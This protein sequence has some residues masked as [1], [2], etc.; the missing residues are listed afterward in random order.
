MKLI[1][2]FGGT[3][4]GSAERIENVGQIIKENSKENQLIINEGFPLR[5]LL[6]IPSTATMFWMWVRFIYE[7]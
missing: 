4:V 3:S 5:S 7:V 2:K 6:W 1:I